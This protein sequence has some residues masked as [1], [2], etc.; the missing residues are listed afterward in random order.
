MYCWSM[1]ALSMSIAY[2]NELRSH[3]IGQ[4]F[5]E[6][7]ETMDD[8]DLARDMFITSGRSGAGGRAVK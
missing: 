5:E 8:V 1:L 3:L 2:N 4:E 6:P 7:L